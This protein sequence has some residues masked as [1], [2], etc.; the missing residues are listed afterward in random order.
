M[1]RTGLVFVIAILCFV[2]L[3]AT[4]L[5]AEHGDLCAGKSDLVRTEVELASDSSGFF[6]RS[7]R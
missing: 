1:K 6:E 2:S 4:V 5:R 3:E 7:E